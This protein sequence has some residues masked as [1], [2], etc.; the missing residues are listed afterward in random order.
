MFMCDYVETFAEEV[1]YMWKG[2]RWNLARIPILFAL[3]SPGLVGTACRAVHTT[4]L[5]S[6]YVGEIFPMAIM[7]LCLFALYDSKTKYAPLFFGSFGLLM[8]A[9]LGTMIVYILD[10]NV[11]L[12]H[13]GGCWLII[14]PFGERFI[15]INRVLRLSAQFVM[16]FLAGW[17]AWKRFHEF[18]T[19]LM[20][21]IYTGGLHYYCG[22]AVMAATDIAARYYARGDPARLKIISYLGRFGT[23]IL[24]NRLILGMYRHLHK[25]NARGNLSATLSG[26][27]F[28][29]A[30][31]PPRGRMSASD[32]S[33]YSGNRTRDYWDTKSGKFEAGMHS[34]RSPVA[35][36]A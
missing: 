17:R 12:P 20:K 26:I 21:A 11:P 3:Y 22:V 15:L 19:P 5:V 8:L 25:G 9:L 1:E 23:P 31:A 34:G 28:N 16:F 24:A 13:F 4:V 2:N 6:T 29:P 7:M 30:P 10:L 14:T 18:N 27:R 33:E 35:P 36:N 32:R